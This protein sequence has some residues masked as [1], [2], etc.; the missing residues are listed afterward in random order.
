MLGAHAATIVLIT[1]IGNPTNKIRK[2][3]TRGNLEKRLVVLLSEVHWAL[4]PPG[5]PFLGG[6]PI[7]RSLYAGSE[8]DDRLEAAL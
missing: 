5:R 3:F 7:L 2:A 8:A 4:H 6:G 1:A